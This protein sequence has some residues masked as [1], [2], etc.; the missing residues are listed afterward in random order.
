MADIAFPVL[1]FFASLAVIMF[2]ISILAKRLIDAYIPVLAI[3]AGVMWITIFATYDNII[4][5]GEPLIENT[6]SI[7][8]PNTAFHM[9]QDTGASFLALRSGSNIFIGE[10][11]VSIASELNTDNIDTACVSLAKSGTPNGIINIAVYDTIITPTSTN[12]LYLFDT[13]NSTTLTTTQSTFCFN[14]NSTKTFSL[15]PNT[16]VGIFFNGGSVGNEVRTF[17]NTTNPFDSTNTVRTAYTSSWSD[18]TTQD[19]LMIL[20]VSAIEEKIVNDLE[21]IKQD[22]GYE[23]NQGALLKLFFILIGFS[24]LIAGIV[25][26]FNFGGNT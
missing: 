24:F 17:V 1:V 11:L 20:S 15:R 8:L 21:Q 10:K 9:Q 16:A 25:E 13:K 22:I 14:S 6:T 19:L 23:T 2:A 18:T 5:F 7:T 4:S 3:L 26:R 12:F